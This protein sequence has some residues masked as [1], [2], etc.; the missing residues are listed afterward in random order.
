MELT[1]LILGGGELGHTQDKHFQGQDFL[2]PLF[3]LLNLPSTIMKTNYKIK[4][5]NENL[6]W[7]IPLSRSSCG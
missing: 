1:Q 5:F 4:P 2:A 7:S 3:K 6:S